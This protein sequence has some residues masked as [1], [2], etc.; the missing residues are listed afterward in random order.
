MQGFWVPRSV[1]SKLPPWAS[2]ATLDANEI[3]ERLLV[4]AKVFFREYRIPHLQAEEAIGHLYERYVKTVKKI[5]PEE[6][7]HTLFINIHLWGAMKDYLHNEN[8]NKARFF[9]GPHVREDDTY[10]IDYLHHLEIK[11][12]ISNGSERRQQ[13]CEYYLQGY[14]QA[15]IAKCMRISQSRVRQLLIGD[16]RNGKHRRRRERN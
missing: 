1:L 2:F 16:N 5:K 14:T 7:K 4:V 12:I 3:H 9:S 13:A 6:M 8:R 15:E 10:E 11:E